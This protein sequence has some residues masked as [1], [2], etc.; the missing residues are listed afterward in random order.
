[1]LQ[2]KIFLHISLPKPKHGE[3]KMITLI[4]LL[5]YFPPSI[6]TR[7]NTHRKD[8]SEIYCR[9]LFYISTLKMSRNFDAALEGP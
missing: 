1:M 7:F 8:F 9:M 3:P 4:N 2:T 6:R 5:E